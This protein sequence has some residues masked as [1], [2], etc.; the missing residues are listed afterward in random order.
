VFKK[1][2]LSGALLILGAA[3]GVFGGW[4]VSAYRFERDRRAFETAVGPDLINAYG[5][6][7]R[8]RV[9]DFGT[10]TRL[11]HPKQ[12]TEGH[13]E[14]LQ[15]TLDAAAKGKKEVTDP[16]VLTLIDMET[17]VAEVR[18]AM[19]E[20]AVGNPSAAHVWMEKAQ[21]AMQASGWKDC[22]EAHLRAV[23]QTMNQQDAL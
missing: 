2:L 20:E 16:T 13:R 5:V 22:S 21:A 19:L 8:L 3:L 10:A 17:G 23:V 11:Q 7:A 14:Y 9:L 4:A 1:T 6:M 12:G 18:L 15:M